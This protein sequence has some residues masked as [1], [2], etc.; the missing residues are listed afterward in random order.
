[1]A[2]PNL[3][4]VFREVAASVAK[5]QQCDAK[6]SDEAIRKLE[7]VLP[8]KFGPFSAERKIA[9]RVFIPFDWFFIGATLVPLYRALIAYK[10]P[11]EAIS[12]VDKDDYES[13]RGGTA[14]PGLAGG[15]NRLPDAQYSNEDK[16]MLLRF[17]TNYG[18][19]H[20]SKTIDRGDFHV[21][22]LCQAANVLAASASFL[23]EEIVPAL[24]SN[25][26][27]TALI[28]GGVTPKPEP[29]PAGALPDFYSTFQ[30]AL[31]EAKF[32]TQS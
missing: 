14:V 20:G 23:V 13:S 1:M 17:V 30:T 9:P 26:E 16:Q 24:S 31:K 25:P 11:L 29:R 28:S 32:A 4:D 22:S 15:I 6:L 3:G 21:S 8:I 19:W 12:G 5:L 10:T 7:Q 27:V 18:W 2:L